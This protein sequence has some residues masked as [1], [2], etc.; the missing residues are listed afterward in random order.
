VRKRCACGLQEEE[1]DTSV[2]EEV[3]G[4]DVTNLALS[5]KVINFI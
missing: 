2:D 4:T 3:V 5:T 1:E